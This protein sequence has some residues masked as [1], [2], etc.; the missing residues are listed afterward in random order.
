MAIHIYSHAALL[1]HETGPHPEC[2]DRIRVMES[3]L[4]EA[5]QLKG[6]LEWRDA[7]PAT[8]RDLLRCHSKEHVDRVTAAAGKSG[9][10]DADTPYSPQS[11]DAARRAAGLTIAA[12]QRVFESGQPAFCLVR[13]P[14][15]HATGK[16]AMG[17]C[18]FNNVAIA[19]RAV[20]Q[21]GCRKVLIVDWDVH[22]GNG[23]QDIFYED[24]TIF[25]YSLHAHPHY[26]GTG[27]SHETGRG[28]GLGTTLN[29]PLPHGFSRRRYVEIFSAD[30]TK[31]H[32]DFAPDLVIVSCGFDA[33]WQDP[34][35][36]LTL[37]D[38]DFATLTARLLGLDEKMRLLSVLEG[39]YNLETLGKSV[40]A[41]VGALERRDL[42]RTNTSRGS[43]DAGARP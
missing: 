20:Q 18:L 28:D 34:L 30:V 38:D 37:R 27:G 42:D 24:A 16:H 25:Y 7:E 29:R 41:H 32:R 1:R 40:A 17:F 33:H 35:G 19:A 6:R 9:R 43:P 12:A 21:M 36:G 13:P 10:F 2:A 4:K 15:H 39:G 31:I 23:T 11:S 14:G 3:S 8:E 22:H 5:P 26:P